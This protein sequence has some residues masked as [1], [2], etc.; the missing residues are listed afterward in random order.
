M[1]NEE[2]VRNFLLDVY[3]Y[4]RI[5]EYIHMGKKTEK[6]NKYLEGTI[7]GSYK[8]N[9]NEIGNQNSK[10]IYWPNLSKVKTTEE[11]LS[12][13]DSSM[14]KKELPYHIMSASFFD[15]QRFTQIK[16]YLEEKVMPFF[17]SV[18]A[19]LESKKGR[20]KWKCSVSIPFFDLNV[21][22]SHPANNCRY[23]YLG[24]ESGKE[25]ADEINEIVSDYRRVRYKVLENK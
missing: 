22:G 16:S 25:L 13:G 7:I 11:L 17:S 19:N 15:G 9:V 4:G 23:L 10:R 1:E 21:V 8:K 18:E 14:M 2:L 24:F 6:L 3:G 20:Y 5:K 12:R